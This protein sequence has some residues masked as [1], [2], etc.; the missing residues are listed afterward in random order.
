[1][2][3][4]AGA[5]GTAAAASPGRG[6]GLTELGAASVLYDGQEPEGLFDV[7]LEGVGGPSL[8]R[9]LRA[10]APRGVVVLYG[11]ASGVGASVGLSSFVPGRFGRIQSFFIYETDGQTFGRDLPYLGYLVDLGL[12]EPQD[13][14]TGSWKDVDS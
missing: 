6:A 13:R 7:V 11:G 8:E 12:L 9:S 1:R 14:A 3:R 10:L 2:G 5:A 4:A